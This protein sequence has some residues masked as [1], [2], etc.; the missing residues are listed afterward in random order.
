MKI[1]ITNRP[2]RM[3]ASVKC[4]RALSGLSLVE[5]KKAVDQK[6]WFGVIHKNPDENIRELRA[7]GAELEFDHARLRIREGWHGA[8]KTGVRLGPDVYVRQHWT[9][10]LWDDE[11]DPD[12][13]K[14][15]GLEKV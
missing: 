15:S 1:R 6:G 4:V 5:A 8:G 7:N 2:Q 14:A 3:I 10:I 12:W 13:H 9:P 11:E